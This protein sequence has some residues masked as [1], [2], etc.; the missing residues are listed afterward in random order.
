M[1]IIII[2]GL[3]AAY[4]VLLNLLVAY[5]NTTMIIYLN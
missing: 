5:Y 4:D 3:V 1:K 2:V